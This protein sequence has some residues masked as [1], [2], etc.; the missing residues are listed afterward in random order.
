[1]VKL[2]LVMLSGA[3]HLGKLRET[4]RFAQ[5]D[6]LKLSFTRKSWLDKCNNEITAL[7]FNEGFHVRF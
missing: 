2:S 4:L 6:N 5:G 7:L 1:M 3:K